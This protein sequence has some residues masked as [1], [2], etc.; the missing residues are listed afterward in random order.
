MTSCNPHTIYKTKTEY[1]VPPEALLQECEAVP[2]ELGATT[3]EDLLKLVS[4]AYVE[5]LQNISS[6]NIKTRAAKDY[7]TKVKNESVNT[8]KDN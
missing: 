6:C 4:K 7:V 1:I 5:T 8:N 3:K 2:V